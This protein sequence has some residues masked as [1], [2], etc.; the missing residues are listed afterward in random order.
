MIDTS[1]ELTADNERRPA[2]LQN[3][4]GPVLVDSGNNVSSSSLP[5]VRRGAGG[6]EFQE[7]LVLN[8]AT[9][10]RRSAARSAVRS[11]RGL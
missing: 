4:A 7:E 10:S 9:L 2:C 8:C 11:V 5:L 6:R 3:L 1:G